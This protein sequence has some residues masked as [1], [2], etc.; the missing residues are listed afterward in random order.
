M[1]QKPHVI[2]IIIFF[3]LLIPPYF[4]NIENDGPVFFYFFE[5]SL[6]QMYWM[7]LFFGMIL[8]VLVLLAIQ[9]YI[10]EIKNAEIKNKFELK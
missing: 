10:Q 5:L 2:S 4:Q 9:A 8:G 3:L 7:F 1:L 6:L